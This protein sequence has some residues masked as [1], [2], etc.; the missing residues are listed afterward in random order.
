MELKD[1]KLFRQQCYVNGEWVDALNRG[2]IPVTNPATGKTLGT[3]PRMGAEETRQAIEAADRALSGWRGK[4][5]KERAQVLRKWFDLM[6]ANQEDL[7]ALMTAEQGKPLAE[8]KGEIAYA[9]SFIE[10]FGEEGKRLYGDVIPGHGAEKRIGVLR[11]P[12]GVVAAITPWNFPRAMIPRKAGPALAAGCTLVCKPAS[13][14]PYSALAAAALA[15][16]AGVPPGVLNVV[17][18]VDAAAIGGELTA[19]PA[20][21]KGTFTGSTAVGKR[22]MA[23][24]A[25]TVKKLTME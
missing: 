7:A 11:H 14:T 24:C 15:A 6:M 21:R 20:V 5:A 9:A 23:Q 19:N 12:V 3:V 22:L 18:G 16:R 17:T 25:G 1:P 8:S 4:T 13:Q 2:T 10:W